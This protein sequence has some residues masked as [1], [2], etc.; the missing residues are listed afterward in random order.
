VAQNW[1]GTGF[2]GQVIPRIG[3]E[4]MVMCLDGDPDRPVVTGV[5]PNSRQ[6]VPYTLPANK[7]KSIFRTNT[8]KG[9]C[10]NGL[11]FEDQKAGRK[12]PC[13]P[14]ATASPLFEALAP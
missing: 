7:T 9:Q 13:M 1:A 8:H 12:S 10:F 6:K 4:V 2:G 3:M 11:S 5:V 14:S